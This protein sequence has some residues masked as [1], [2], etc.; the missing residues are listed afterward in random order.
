M[1]IEEH[2]MKVIRCRIL[3]HEVPFGYCR[4]G[5]GPRSCRR[6]F[7]CWYEHFDITAFMQKHY[8]EE[9]IQRILEPPRDKMVSLY[10][11]IQKA[12]KMAEK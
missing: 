11:L 8:S 9:D 10:E 5:T 6:I 2:D 12:R 4:T 1:A 7:D 3:G